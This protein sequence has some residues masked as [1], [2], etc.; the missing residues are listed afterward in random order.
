VEGPPRPAPTS[1]P[2]GRSAKPAEAPPPSAA[3]D[4]LDAQTLS[5]L[6]EQMLG[7]RLDMAR[8]RNNAYSPKSEVGRQASGEIDRL[9][10]EYRRR[11]LTI[12]VPK[13]GAEQKRGK[14]TKVSSEETKLSE[15]PLRMLGD[16]LHES[17]QNARALSGE[18]ALR[19]RVSILVLLEAAPQP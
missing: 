1:F 3:T 10:R 8:Q 9:T 11:G 19:H 16:R 2:P 18:D 15:V 7:D 13:T 5:K 17:R 14:G 12:P 6:T 4:A